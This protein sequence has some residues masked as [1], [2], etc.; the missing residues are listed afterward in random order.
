MNTTIDRLA[1]DVS[2]LQ[3]TTDWDVVIRRLEEA[4]RQDLHTLRQAR[5]GNL[6]AVQRAYQLL[7]GRPELIWGAPPDTEGS[8]PTHTVAPA[9]PARGT[10]PQEV[11]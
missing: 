11:K 10:D 4:H 9:V 8:P 5:D 1:I 6:L 3:P 7:V 2:R